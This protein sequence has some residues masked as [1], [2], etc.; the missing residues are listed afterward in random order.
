MRSRAAHTSR[1]GLALPTAIFTLVAMSILAASLFTFVDL[2]A[3]SV[4]NRESATRATHVAEAG[5][6]H[7]LGLLRGSLK[8]RSFSTILKGA[9]G[10][11]G[12]ADDSLFINWPG[13]SAGDQ[14]PLVGQNYQGHTYFVSLRDDPADGDANQGTDLN[15][16][17]KIRC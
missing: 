9:D 16:R 1:R 12:N 6:N 13:L 15:G 14:I 8:S 10:V 3:K 11:A 2:N 4:R 5:V 17:V 7:A